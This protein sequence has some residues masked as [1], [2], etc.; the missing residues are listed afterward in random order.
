MRPL[1]FFVCAKEYLKSLW[2]C[3]GALLTPVLSILARYWE[4]A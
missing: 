3:V 2:L 1:C 4:P